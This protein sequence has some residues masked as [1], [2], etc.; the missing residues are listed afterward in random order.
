MTSLDLAPPPE[1]PA[2]AP[3]ALPLP[4]DSDILL[5]Y[6]VTLLDA[7]AAAHA[8]LKRG[9]GGRRGIHVS[10]RSQRMVSPCH[11]CSLPL[12]P[13]PQ[14]RLFSGPC[15]IT[16]PLQGTGEGADYDGGRGYDGGSPLLSPLLSPTAVAAV[17][18]SGHGDGATSRVRLQIDSVT[19]RLRLQGGGGRRRWLPGGSTGSG[20]ASGSGSSGPLVYVLLDGQAYDVGNDAGARV[21][22]PRALGLFA[23]LLLKKAR[24]CYGGGAGVA[25]GVI[26]LQR[27]LRR[28]VPPA[29]GGAPSIDPDGV[30]SILARD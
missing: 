16:K 3:G 25:G 22:V 15:V 4:R 27:P 28:M 5:R 1:Q 26:D 20:A 24:G 14:D 12:H 8:N 13:P 17:A 21:A 2:S 18:G 30:W 23:H 7:E 9:G 11:A 10:S 19:P 6:F 29:G